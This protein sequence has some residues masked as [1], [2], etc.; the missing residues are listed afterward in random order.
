MGRIKP[1][2]ASGSD[3]FDTPELLLLLASAPTQGLHIC[4]GLPVGH[5]TVA[6]EAAKVSGGRH[7]FADWK[8]I[9]PMTSIEVLGCAGDFALVRRLMPHAASHG[10][11]SATHAAQF[12]RYARTDHPHEAGALLR[13]PYG[14]E[15]LA[16]IS[17]L[18]RRLLGLDPWPND[19]GSTVR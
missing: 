5:R 17:P 19:M 9:P 8:W 1:Y 6:E 4:S 2:E 14:M 15:Q 10:H 11:R 16:A 13:R 7:R 12:V 3:T 18:G